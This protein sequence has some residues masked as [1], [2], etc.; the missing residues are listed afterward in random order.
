MKNS[1]PILYLFVF[2]LS[3]TG[4]FSQ[5]T[6]QWGKTVRLSLKRIAVDN[7]GNSYASW[8]LEDVYGFD[9]E[10]FISHGSNDIALTGFDC[11]GNHRWTKIIE[12]PGTD[13]GVAI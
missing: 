10:V 7:V 1:N 6:W 12:G 13:A 4:L 9:D 11:D 8:P 3:S 5:P 2:L